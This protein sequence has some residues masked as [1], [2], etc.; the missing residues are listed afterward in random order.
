[1]PPDQNEWLSHLRAQCT[2]PIATGELFN[3]PME[4]RNLIINRQIDYIRCHV[5]QIGGITPAL[6]LAALCENFG[7]RI[8]WHGPSDM[9][10]IGVAVNTHLNI[11]LHN[12]A[13]QEIQEPDETTKKMFPHS[14][15]VLEGYIY[16]IETVGIGVEFDE[17]MA[18]SILLSIVNTNGLK[19]EY[20]M[21]QFI[22][23]SSYKERGLPIGSVSFFSLAMKRKN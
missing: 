22:H 4:W 10:P 19:R 16:P 20:Q 18:E 15:E 17:D 14:V 9:T 21:V 3:N 1:M 13:I 23:H 12:A 7:V 5:S 2:T 6:K 11:H 8:A